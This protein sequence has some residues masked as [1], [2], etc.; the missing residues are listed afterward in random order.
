MTGRVARPHVVVVGSGIIGRSVAWRLAEREAIVTVVD[1]DPSKAAARVAAGMVAPVTE[2]SFGEE[3]LFQLN[4][5]SARRWPEFADELA[6]VAGSASGYV[7]SG[8][9]SVAR[10]SDDLAVIEHLATFLDELDQDVRRLTSRELRRREPALSP[11][12]RGGLAV[13]GDHQVD[14]RRCLAALQLALDRRGVTSVVDAAVAVEPDGVHLRSGRRLG[15]DQVVVCAGWASGSLLDLPVRPVKGQVVRLG[16]T[17][18]AVLPSHVVRGLDIYLATRPWGEIVVGATTE[19]RGPD[20]TTTAGPVRR[21]LR[22][23]W[24][25]VPGL[26]E[27]PLQETAAGLRPGTPDNAPLLGTRSDGVHVAT[28]HYRNGM[29]LAPITAAAVVEAVLGPGWPASIAP[30]SVDRFVD[31]Q[32]GEQE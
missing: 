23:G 11:T 7:P 5:E 26:D 24:E 6:A 29:L 18:R 27:A 31:L 28:G 9:L 12:V 32:T 21:L 2:A 20:T 22:D 10:D 13:A 17:D 8:T 1:P 3:N 15:G 30:F 16:A 14:P 19:E 25:L 4:L